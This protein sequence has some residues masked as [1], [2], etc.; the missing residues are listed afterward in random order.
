MSRPKPDALPLGDGPL[1]FYFNT[2]ED[3]LLS[4][5]QSFYKQSEDFEKIKIL[6]ELDR[7]PW[8]KKFFGY[9][10]S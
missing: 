2:R 5:N 8:L 1:D 6:F 7:F 10:D 3:F 9:F 4:K